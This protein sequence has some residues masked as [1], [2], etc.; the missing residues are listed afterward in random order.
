MD[1]QVRKVIQ[2]SKAP[3]ASKVYEVRQV[4]LDNLVQVATWAF[5]ALL[6]SSVPVEDPEI[7][8]C[9]VTVEHLVVLDRVDSQ[10]IRVG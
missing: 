9:L 4:A 3:L 1:S 8:V 2:A 7:L 10:E 5:Q 6:A